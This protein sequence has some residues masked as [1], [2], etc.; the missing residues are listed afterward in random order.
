MLS[1]GGIRTN[2]L[3]T[4]EGIKGLLPKET[5]LIF[6]KENKAEMTPAHYLCWAA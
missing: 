1:S 6:S 4:I 3:R 5:K 2:P